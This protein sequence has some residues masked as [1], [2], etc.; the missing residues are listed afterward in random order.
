MS[1]LEFT[2]TIT[3]EIRLIKGK[4]YT[5]AWSF[6]AAAKFVSKMVEDVLHQK[7]VKPQRI[8]VK[9]R[10]LENDFLKVNTDGA[11]DKVQN[12]GGTGAILRNR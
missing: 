12:S 2:Y 4:K 3:K 9:W 8:H 7:E 10:P 5:P 6:F 11:F 1:A